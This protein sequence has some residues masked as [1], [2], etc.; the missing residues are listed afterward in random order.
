MQQPCR[1]NSRPMS[2]TLQ[3]AGQRSGPSAGRPSR[4]SLPYPS[5]LDMVRAL[6]MDRFVIYYDELAAFAER[7]SSG[8]F[9][10]LCA[11]DVA[12]KATEWT[13]SR[14]T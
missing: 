14:Q 4:V 10:F 8:R 5:S 11:M 2:V 3:I 9:R 1:S 7:T 13:L 12:S 6:H